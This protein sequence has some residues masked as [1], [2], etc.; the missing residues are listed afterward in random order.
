MTRASL[1]HID[2]V[3]WQQLLLEAG[4][5]ERFLLG[6]DR[7]LSGGAGL[8]GAGFWEREIQRFTLQLLLYVFC[9]DNDEIIGGDAGWRR[10]G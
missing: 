2:G 3:T 1:R 9:L 4:E 6:G 10:G 5:V 7:Q 8:S